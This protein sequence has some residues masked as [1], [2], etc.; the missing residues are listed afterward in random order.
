MLSDYLF[1]WLQ[2]MNNYNLLGIPKLI[3]HSIKT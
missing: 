2:I 1:K 3:S